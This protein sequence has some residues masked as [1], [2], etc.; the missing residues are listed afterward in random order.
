MKV[1][2]RLIE[3]EMKCSYLDYSMSVIVGRALPD[4]RDGLKPVHRR[5]LYTMYQIG[6]LHNKPFKKSANVVGT[7]MARFHPHGDAPIY[8]ALVRLAQPFSLRYPLVDGQGNFGSIDGDS[9]AAMRYTEA[10]L[11]RIA[12]EMLRDIDKETVPF[13]LNFDGSLKEPNVLPSRIP[14]L[15]LNGSSGIAVGMA[16]NIPPH[17]LNEI[18]DALV[19]LIDRPDCGFEE[20]M[21]VIK[22]PDFPTGGLVL[23]KRSILKAYS[24]GRGRIVLRAKTRIEKG[25]IIIEEIPYALSK[26]SLVKEIAQLVQEQRVKGI[27]AIRDESDRSGI[28]IVLMLSHGANPDV[29]LN[30]LFK[31]SRL[32]VTYGIIMLAIVDG[33]PRILNIKEMLECFIRH[34]KEIVRARTAYELKKARERAH[35]VEGLIRALSALDST[36]AAIKSS[37]T[38]ADAKKRLI[39]LLKITEKQADAIL[40]M[41]L[42]KLA[43]MEQKK[44]RDEQSEL[45]NKINA[46]EELLSA[47]SRLLEVVRKELLELKNM[48][49]DDRRTTILAEEKSIFEEEE[50]IKPE[51]VAI[52]VTK[53]GFVKR[54]PLSVY[55]KQH[56]G[57]KGIITAQTR[58]EDFVQEVLIANTHSAL[59]CFTDKGK[60]YKLNVYKLPEGTRYSAGR[61]I[62]MLLRLKQGEHITALCA[63]DRFDG[64]L[65]F[66][67]E[68][69]IVK[70][71][72]TASFSK[73]RR[74]GT[75][76]IKLDADRLVS[77]LRLHGGEDILI[78][79]RNGMSIRFN[80]AE[81]RRMG[82]TAQ[83]VRGIRLKDGDA[84][85][86]AVIAE[87]GKDILTIT[88]NGYGKRTPLQLY[89][90]THRGG[91]GI[92]NLK[93]TAKTGA[94][95][96]VKCVDDESALV[97][98]T[99]NGMGINISA[100]EIG[101]IGRATQGIRIMKVAS[102]DSISSIARI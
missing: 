69:G 46:F 53:A 5:V 98:V 96:G 60:V 57:G 9:Q 28:R 14:N 27:S 70:K 8:D 22:G 92:I 30:Q 33:R 37:R 74:S 101:R 94:V 83:G 16:T 23:G 76:A 21:N 52:I 20:L 82:R 17:N 65:L 56:K 75:Q 61:S 99:K 78:A 40:E 7:C 85:V 19:M 62:R 2:Q 64:D 25:R 43:S 31:H 42:H 87:P 24:T 32:Q 73:L 49:G 41:K 84:V 50:L 63:V 86:G 93:R 68:G 48:Y 91:F 47:E 26:S 89:R 90:R 100:S 38:V 55:R 97:L 80:E 13:V 81:I 44:L 45:M 72:A 102:G 59:L 15:L 51:D 1:S 11:S 34:R 66:V 35:L 36:I 10:R 54:M 29:V 67:T 4:V 88:S 58:D 12:E 6:L 95:I 79:T 3:E 77:V 39:D 18:I 71:T